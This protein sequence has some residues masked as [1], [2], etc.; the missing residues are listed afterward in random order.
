VC[1]GADASCSGA[2]VFAVVVAMISASYVLLSHIL[3]IKKTMCNNKILKNLGK[4]LS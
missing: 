1:F 4:G 3:D 2:D